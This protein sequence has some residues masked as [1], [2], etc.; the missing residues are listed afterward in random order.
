MHCDILCTPPPINNCGRGGDFP[1]FQKKTRLHFFSTPGWKKI[2][3]NKKSSGRKKNRPPSQLFFQKCDPAF[4]FLPQLFFQKCD[5]NFF[6]YSQLIFKKCDH[7]I[8]FLYPPINHPLQ[9]FSLPPTHSPPQFKKKS[10][11]PT[12]F[13]ISPIIF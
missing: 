11:T 4:F 6:F 8:F 7:P 9:F 10:A 1:N 2:K 12:I 3:N 5:P 13:S